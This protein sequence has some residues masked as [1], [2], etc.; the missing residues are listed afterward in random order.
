MMMTLEYHIIQLLRENL[1]AKEP[2]LRELPQIYLK[3]KYLKIG[4][5][6]RLLPEYEQRYWAFQLKNLK[7]FWSVL[8]KRPQTKATSLLIFSVVLARP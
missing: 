5:I 6:F 2:D 8:S 4:G 1:K 7:S 3:G